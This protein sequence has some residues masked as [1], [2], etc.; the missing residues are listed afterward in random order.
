[1]DEM[2]R[3]VRRLAAAVQNS[4]SGDTN[5]ASDNR[6]WENEKPPHY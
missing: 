4:R 3:E 6:L 5:A 2:R 1:M